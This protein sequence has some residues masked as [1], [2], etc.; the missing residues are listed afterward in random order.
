MGLAAKKHFRKYTYSD[1]LAWD[2]NQRWEIVNGEAYDMSPGPGTAHQLIAA[3]L[4][5][6]IANQL[7]GRPCNALP[8][9]FDVRLPLG[10]EKEEDIENIVQPD[11]SI[12]CDSSK[13][14]EKGCL[15][16]PDII[17]EILSPS[18]VR[19]DKLEKFNLY[20]QAGVK[21]YWLVSQAD[22][23]V[24]VFTLGETGKYG[25]PAIYGESSTIPFNTIKDITIDFSKIFNIGIRDS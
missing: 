8:A 18:S 10:E 1:Y 6:Q 16:A 20:E 2:D 12:I 24:E 5:R 9:P 13:L 21:E 19:R 15:G 3:E 17:I 22:K 23:M 14:D 4:M 25:R 11:I 7:E